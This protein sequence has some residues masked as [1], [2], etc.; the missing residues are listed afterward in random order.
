[1]LGLSQASYNDQILARFSMQDSKKGFVPFRV[2]SSLSA[3][4]RPKTPTE[5][6][7]MR[8]RGI[9]YASVVESFMYAMLC[10]RPDI[11][12][13]I[14]MVSRYQS[15]PGEEHWIAVKH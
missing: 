1:M 9:P 14:G 5:I 10:T 6:E 11:C 15:D 8:M 2:E 12:F 4:Q 7:R 13:A 3:N